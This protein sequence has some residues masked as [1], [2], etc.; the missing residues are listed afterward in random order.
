[1]KVEIPDLGGAE[2]VL[3]VE[4]LVSVG[5]SVAADQGLITLESDKASMDIPAPE[6]GAVEKI[7]VKVGDEVVE[8][9][10]IMFS[11]GGRVVIPQ[12]FEQRTSARR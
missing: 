12:R 3:V 8:G 6:A 11:V 7:L 1:M 9:Q 2:K 4:I 5:D 10:A